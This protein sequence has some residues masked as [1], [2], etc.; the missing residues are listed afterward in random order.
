MSESSFPLNKHSSGPSNRGA[1]PHRCNGHL[2]DLLEGLS[3][4]PL[5]VSKP[6]SVFLEC[7]RSKP[8]QEPPRYSE[9]QQKSS[10]QP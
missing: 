9:Q 1:K 6:F 8:G 7:M 10:S 2:E 4:W 5:N 3:T